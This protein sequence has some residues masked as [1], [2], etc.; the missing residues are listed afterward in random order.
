MRVWFSGPR[1]MGIRPGISLGKE[2]TTIAVFRPRRAGRGDDS[3]DDHSH[4]GGDCVRRLR[5]GVKA[6][7]TV[8]FESAAIAAGHPDIIGGD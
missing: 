2:G 3:L 6:R 7:T 4:R 8:K 5:Q 1:I